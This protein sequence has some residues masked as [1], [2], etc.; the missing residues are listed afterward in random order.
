[1]MGRAVVLAIRRSCVNESGATPASNGA[2]DASCGGDLYDLARK[3]RCDGHLPHCGSAEMKRLGK[4]RGA[5]GEDYDRGQNAADCG[6]Y[7]TRFHAKRADRPSSGCRRER[8][9]KE[10]APGGSHQLKESAQA[11][12]IEDRHPR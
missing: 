11:V 6:A 3:E 2:I 12:W 4:P 10:E 5:A 8:I 9:S 1:M 7:I